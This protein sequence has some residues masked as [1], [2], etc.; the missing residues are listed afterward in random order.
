[1]LKGTIW[2]GGTE[3]QPNLARC[4]R[5]LRAWHGFPVEEFSLTCRLQPV[6]QHGDHKG[7]KSCIWKRRSLASPLRSPFPASCRNP[8]H[9]C[10]R[11]DLTSNL[12]PPP[13]S[14]GPLS[15]TGQVWCLPNQKFHSAWRMRFW[16]PHLN[17]AGAE[18]SVGS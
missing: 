4:A 7:T 13:V 9:S 5:G 8:P 10:L 18:M 17:Q 15:I 6:L 3:S 2:E 12:P 14:E 16:F 1:M 11:Q